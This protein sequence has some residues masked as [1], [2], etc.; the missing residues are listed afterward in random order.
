M[1]TPSSRA[2]WLLVPFLSLCA[3]ELTTAIARADEPTLARGTKQLGGQLRLDY[4]RDLY[5]THDTGYALAIVPGF[6]Y[7]VADN[8]EVRVGGTVLTQ[9]GLL[10]SGSTQTLG[11]DGGLRY[12]VRLGPS[13][14]VYAGVA[15]GPALAIPDAG[16]SATTLIASVPFGLLIGFN[17]YVAMDLGA[18]G[19]YSTL[20]STRDGSALEWSAGYFGID[21]FFD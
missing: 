2:R 9:W 12:H 20:V 14:A 6:G 8:F 17:R 16:P 1:F 10:Y 19:E 7:F 15:F 18:R 5:G 3:T 21:A 4:T 13:V 11:F